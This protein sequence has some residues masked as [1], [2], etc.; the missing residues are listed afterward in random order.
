M[1][2]EHDRV[3]LV[4][5]FFGHGPHIVFGRQ[6]RHGDKTGGWGERGRQNLGRLLSTELAAVPNLVN[7]EAQAV[8]QIGHTLCFGMPCRGQRSS[9]VDFLGLR[10]AVLDE[11]EVHGV[12]S[13]GCAGLAALAGH[14]WQSCHVRGAQWV[15]YLAGGESVKPHWRE[16][17][18]GDVVKVRANNAKEPSSGAVGEIA[19]TW[20]NTRMWSCGRLRKG[21]EGIL[22]QNDQ[23]KKIWTEWKNVI[24]VTIAVVVTTS[25]MFWLPPIV[26]LVQPDMDATKVKTT[27][28]QVINMMWWVVF[29]LAAQS[30]FGNRKKRKAAKQAAEEA[31]AALLEGTQPSVEGEENSRS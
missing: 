25:A 27:A 20:Y 1:P 21:E 29:I 5:E 2:D 26:K 19:Q 12:A 4:A 23:M 6:A 3:R 11:I 8:Q 17:G 14:A 31:K 24:L 15:L 9:G 18:N 22:L 30:M 7:V 28:D 13:S 10:V 16:G